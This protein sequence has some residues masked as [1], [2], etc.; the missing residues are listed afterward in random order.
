MHAALELIKKTN[1]FQSGEIVGVACSGGI[2]SMSLLHF[3]NQQKE[4]LDIEVVAINVDHKIRVNSALDSQFVADYCKENRIRCVKLSVDAVTIAKD[5]KLTLEEGARYGRYGLFDALLS[6]GIVD[7]IALGHHVKDQVETILLNIFRGC[8]LKG[9]SGME[10][11][12]QK[13]V[14]PF[15]TTTKEEIIA[16]ASQNKI[17]YV[18]DETNFENDCSRNIIRNKIMPLIMSNWHNVEQN[19]MSFA[20]LCKMDDEFISSQIGY[21]GL[22]FEKDAVKIPLSYFL[23]K[24]SVTTRIL[25]HALEYLGVFKD[26]ER[27]HFNIICDMVKE[28]KNGTKISLPHHIVCHKEY[29]CL[30][31]ICQKPAPYFSPIKLKTGEYTFNE[32][33]VF[34]LTKTKK[35]NLS[36]ACANN[37]MLDYK[38]LPKN[39]VIRMREEGDVFAA[40]NGGSKK[41][42]DWFITKKIPAR[43]RASIPLIACDKEV[44]AVFGYEISDKVKI[45]ENTTEILKIFKR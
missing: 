11:V 17:N 19:I 35:I 26:I 30:T 13:Y 37:L 15:L 40:F 3:L 42:K 36:E 7:K 12:R 28:A 39:C 6:K 10:P 18:D 27:K 31:L 29:D 33:D 25:R 44:F 16:Y 2:D 34:K 32:N 23:F 4:E 20:S 45:D 14:R 9:A 8:G 43:K 5:N 24:Q 22:T 38:K 1:M 21:D 41:L